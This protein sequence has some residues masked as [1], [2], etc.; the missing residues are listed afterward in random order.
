MSGMASFGSISSRGSLSGSDSGTPSINDPFQYDAPA[1][2][3]NVLWQWRCS[4]CM[5]CLQVSG[6]WALASNTP[7]FLGKITAELPRFLEDVSILADQA[8]LDDAGKICAAIRYA[9]L[10]EAELWETLDS[11]TAVLAVWADFVMAVKQLYPGCEGADRYYRSDLHNLVQEYWVKPMKNRE[12]LGEYHRKFQ[13]VATHL[14]STAKLSVNERDLLFLDGLPH[15]LA[16]PPPQPFQQQPASVQPRNSVAW[17]QTVGQTGTPSPT[18]PPPGTVVKQEY[19]VPGTQAPRITTCAF[20]QDPSHFI[21]NCELALAYINEGKL[22]CRNGHLC[23]ADGSPIL[24][25]QGVYSMR[26][27]VDHLLA[28]P[29]ASTKPTPLSGFVRDPPP[30]HITAALYTTAYGDDNGLETELEIEP[31]AFLHTSS[32]S[33]CVPDSSEVA[34]PEFQAFLA[35]T[36]ANFQAGKGKGDQSNGKKT[37]F[38]GVEVLQRKAPRVTVEEEIESPASHTLESQPTLDPPSSLSRAVI[39]APPAQRALS[40]G[41]P[42]AKPMPTTAPVR[43]TPTAAQQEPSAPDTTPCTLSAPA[44]TAQPVNTS[45]VPQSSSQFRHSFPLADSEAPKCTLDQVLGVTIQVPLKELLALSLDLRKHMK[46]AV[47]G[48]RVWGNLLTQAGSETP[49]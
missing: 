18:S 24:H 42:I 37:Q 19:P 44:M 7:K 9:A 46:E 13:K 30:P 11:A 31:P 1:D 12:E 20:C 2:H 16:A 38:D 49:A 40:E 3:S 23:M 35:N 10:D 26:N 15:A 47:T 22:S 14:I 27:V 41:Q 4:Q 34:D 17:P 29:A 28:Q 6:F 33:L 21:P 48:K 39:L 43:S 5:L 25:I 36:W 45:S 8:Q 32:T